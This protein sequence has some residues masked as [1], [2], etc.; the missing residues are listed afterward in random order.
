MPRTIDC[1]IL[2]TMLLTMDMQKLLIN[3]LNGRQI[4]MY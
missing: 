2:N 1:G 3:L 4:M